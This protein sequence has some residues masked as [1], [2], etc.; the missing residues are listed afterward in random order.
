MAVDRLAA[1]H[2]PE[3]FSAAFPHYESQQLAA[4]YP[5]FAH[6]SPH[7]MFLDALVAQGLPGLAALCGICAIGFAATWRLRT[8]RATMAA[9]LAAALAAGIVSQ[10]FVVFTIPTAVIFH[11]IVAVAV[12]LAYDTVP[13]SRR[14]LSKAL[15]LAA[16]AALVYFGARF[17]IAD[18]A[19]A[20]TQ[21]CINLGDAALASADYATYEH[22]R[23]PGTAADLWYSRALLDLSRR[24]KDPVTALHATIEAG[25]AALRAT[26]TAE[27]PA[28]AWYNL[29][30]FYATRNDAAGAEV[31]LR[32]AIA[33]NS[34][35][36]KPHWTLAQMLV[37]ESRM[38]EARREAALAAALDGGKFPEVTR[39]LYEIS[40]KQDHGV[41]QRK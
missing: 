18:R 20:Q 5:D 6:E 1:G 26:R 37:I 30:A 31:S 29:A 23:L 24:S 41:A 27:Y 16:A 21:R 32:A 7:N 12:G 19:L 9:W 35:W 2:G 14:R 25:A 22:W 33:A 40:A 13:T 17:A 3:V 38:E 8:K 10:Q 36:F 11:I 28:N 34:K 39:T 15:A 4:A